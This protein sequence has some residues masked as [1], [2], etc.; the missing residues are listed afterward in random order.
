M[1]L[2]ERGGQLSKVN[3]MQPI[4]IAVIAGLVLAA[5]ALTPAVAASASGYVTANVNERAGPS[6]SYPA[7]TIIPAASAVTV[8]GCLSDRSWCDIS[9][10][11]NRGW[12]SSLYLQATYRSRRVAL[13][14]YIAPLGIPFISFNFGSY[15]NSHYRSKPFYS[16]RSRW[17]GAPL[18]F[19]GPAPGN[20]PPPAHKTYSP[21]TFGSGTSH[22]STFYKGTV[23]GKGTMTGPKFKLKG[24]G[25]TTGSGGQNCVVKDG[26]KICK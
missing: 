4:K 16:Q 22:P 11:P 17:S 23:T 18:S 6:T 12:M 10:G 9:W 2:G 5:S 8:Y 7:I 14:A 20:P 25:Q 15:W 1:W 26:K 13:P 3:R 19:K 21:K 24:G